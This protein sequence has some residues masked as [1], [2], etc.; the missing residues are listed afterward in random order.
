MITVQEWQLLLPITKI[1]FSMQQDEFLY[2][3]VD[4][5][6]ANFLGS[7]KYSYRMTVVSI[8]VTQLNEY[9]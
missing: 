1:L 4:G 8:T 2:I 5:S 3:Y 7:K 6:K 9:G